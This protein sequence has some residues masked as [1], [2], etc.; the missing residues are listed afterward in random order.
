MTYRDVQEKITQV[1]TDVRYRVLGAYD[2]SGVDGKL[3][4][5][6]ERFEAMPQTQRQGVAT[7][8]V[9]GAMLFCIIFIFGPTLQHYLQTHVTIHRLQDEVASAKRD[10]TNI[11]MT[12]EAVAKAG[13]V[14]IELEERVIQGDELSEFLEGLSLMA[15]TSE[16]R[17]ESFKPLSLLKFREQWPK[18]MPQGYQLTGF[19]VRARVEYHQ[20]G[21]FLA[22]LE[23]HS[24]FVQVKDIEIYHNPKKNENEHEATVRL[25]L[26]QRVS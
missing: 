16:I 18:M 5:Y 26:I 8:S 2:K 10:I 15:R 12:R 21:N 24:T 1:G 9:L 14:L 6:R 7:A 4:P 19:E 17:I 23:N 13:A 25:Q 22:L 11:P 3:K 20:L